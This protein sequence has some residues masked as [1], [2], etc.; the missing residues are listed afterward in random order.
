MMRNLKVAVD[1][2]IDGGSQVLVVGGED[3]NAG[4]RNHDKVNRTV[5]PADEP[6]RRVS[7]GGT[8]DKGG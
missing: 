3:E 1:A 2:S 6:R 8:G 5:S 4:L 7:V